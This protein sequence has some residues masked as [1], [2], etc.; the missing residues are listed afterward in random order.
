MLFVVGCVGGWRKDGYLYATAMSASANISCSEGGEA[1]TEL[2]GWGAHTKQWI[3]A[4][5]EY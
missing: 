3:A 5:H 1:C 4:L 2:L